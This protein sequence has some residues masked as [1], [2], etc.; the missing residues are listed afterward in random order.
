MK[1]KTLW[2]VGDST[3]SSFSDRYYYPRYG[4]GTMLEAYLDSEIVVANL[5]LSGR[6]SKSFAE[7]ENYRILLEGMKPGDFLLAGF[8]HNDEK[9][10]AGRFTAGTGDYQDEGSFAHSLYVRYIVPAKRAGCTPI[11]CTPIVRRT[12]TGQWD[13]AQL[14]VTEDAGTYRG[15]DYAQ[16]IR[17]LQEA[18]GIAVI[19]MT[20][21]TKELYDVLGPLETLYL[22]A[23]TSDNQLSVDNTHTNIWGARVNAFLCLKAL[24]EQKIDGIS[25]HIRISDDMADDMFCKGNIRI[26]SKEVYLTKNCDYVPTR[27]NPKLEDSRN[28]KSVGQ[29]KGTV[30]GDVSEQPSMKNFVL[31][32]TKDGIHIA[33]KNNAGK[34]A[35]VS[36]GIAMYYTRLPARKRFV[37]RAKAKIHDYFLNDQV[38]FGLMVRDDI[39]VDKVTADILG[40]YVAAAP[41]LL[42]RGRD[43]VNCFAR[44]SGA[45]TY[46]LTCT[47]AYQP[48]EV[49]DL[50]LSSTQDGYACRFAKEDMVTGGFDFPLTAVDP[51][52]VYVGM[53]VARNADITFFDICLE[54]Q[55]DEG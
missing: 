20:A 49:V 34:I 52:H 22:H 43:C 25:E 12:P 13:S 3:L 44:R 40:D 47:R 42:T 38:S 15:G 27:F 51:E 18:L 19:D 17:A 33:V 28:W 5:A 24:K 53:F 55:D 6:S 48:G 50:Y 32:E 46:G 10:E 54:M 39:Y 11:L 4:Y 31:E 35:A 36:D 16:A 23:W 30:F 8:G 29:W 26:P 41:L 1:K 2:V 14:H 45:L 37:L 9:T 21:A 7:E